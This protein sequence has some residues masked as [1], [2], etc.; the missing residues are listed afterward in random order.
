[1]LLAV[2]V[3]II[4]LLVTLA[5]MSV[6]VIFAVVNV[7]VADTSPKHCNALYKMS[8]KCSDSCRRCRVLLFFAVAIFFSYK[9]TPPLP[10][11]PP[12][13]LQNAIRFPYLRSRFANLLQTVRFQKSNPLNHATGN[14]H[15]GW[16]ICS[17]QSQKGGHLVLWHRMWQVLAQHRG[18]GQ[19]SHDT[20]EPNF[21]HLRRCNNLGRDTELL[22]TPYKFLFNG[23]DT[24][25]DW[26]RFTRQHGRTA[27][28][29][30]TAVPFRIRR[31]CGVYFAICVQAA[32]VST[33]SRFPAK[34]AIPCT[35]FYL[36]IKWVWSIWCGW[37]EGGTHW[38]KGALNS[39]CMFFYTSFVKTESP[40]NLLIWFSRPDL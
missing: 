8:P 22:A 29:R 23:C 11:P 12:R 13:I 39:L 36:Q 30:S 7:L 5:K 40:E 15:H 25:N 17:S 26:T 35:D 14:R 9:I 34:G 28:G 10:L 19:K 21:D 20:F 32:A 18:N 4:I 16:F 27:D 6:F 24:T 2:V 37:T 1:M 3:V 33:V 31:P 38:E